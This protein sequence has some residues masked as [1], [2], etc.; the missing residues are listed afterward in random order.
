MELKEFVTQTLVQIIEGV[1]DAQQQTKDSGALINP[2]TFRNTGHSS[3]QA[4]I[5]KQ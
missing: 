1:K 4:Q 2:K 3:A 5:L